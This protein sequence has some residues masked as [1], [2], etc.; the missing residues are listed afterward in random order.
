MDPSAARSELPRSLGLLDALA[1]VIG[2]VIGGGIFVVPN[3]I[4]R[5]LHSL[6]HDRGVGVCRSG[7]LLWCVGMRRTRGHATGHWWPIRFHARGMGTARRIPLWL[8]HVSGGTHCPSSMARCD[9]SALLLLLFSAI[10]IT[11]EA[12][13]PR[14]YRAVHHHQLSECDPRCRSSEIVHFSE[15]ARTG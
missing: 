2:I 12:V 1:I 4:A 10:R 11:V 5:E 6:P 13:G 8:V 15:V 3:L 7:L 9:T 14:C